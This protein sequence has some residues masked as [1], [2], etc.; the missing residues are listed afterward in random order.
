MCR[1]TLKEMSEL[2][3]IDF[4]QIKNGK[5]VVDQVNGLVAKTDVVNAE[6]AGG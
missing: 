1:L 4:T 3:M 6:H 5:K 2:A